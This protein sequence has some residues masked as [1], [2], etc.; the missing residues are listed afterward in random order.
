MY[1]YVKYVN[2]TYYSKLLYKCI[3]MYVCVL[4]HMMNHNSLAANSCMHIGLHDCMETNCTRLTSANTRWSIT[5]LVHAT[6]SGLMSPE[7]SSFL[8]ALCKVTSHIQLHSVALP[9]TFNFTV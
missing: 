1:M 3:H 4:A 9:L 7:L 6:L 2:S 5:C 8:V